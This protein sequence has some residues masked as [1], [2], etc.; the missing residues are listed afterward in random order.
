MS[1]ARPKG[2]DRTIFHERVDAIVRWFERLN[3]YSFGGSILKVEDYNF[4]LTD[5][6]KREPLYCWCVSAKRYALFNLTPA[7]KPIIRKASAHG[8]GHLIALYDEKNPAKGIPG[9][10][11]KLSKIGVERWQYDLWYQI[12]SAALSANP[13]IVDLGYHPALKLPAVSRYGASTPTQLD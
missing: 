12:V 3:P 6:R 13:N 11:G 1:I 9:P 2:M 10:Q 4:S 5:P 7:R 8:L